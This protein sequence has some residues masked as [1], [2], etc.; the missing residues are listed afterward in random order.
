MAIVLFSCQKL[1]EAHSA[2][3]RITKESSLYNVVIIISQTSIKTALIDKNSKCFLL[4]NK[5]LGDP[6]DYQK[7][8]VK[9]WKYNEKTFNL[10]LAGN[11]GKTDVIH[12]K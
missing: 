12:E 8:K 6:V 5:S 2:K 3:T 10:K 7:K 9:Q 1:T 4:K 11:L